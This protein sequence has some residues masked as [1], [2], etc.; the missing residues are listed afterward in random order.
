MVARDKQLHIW[1]GAVIG[2]SALV[3]HW[4]WA[5]ALVLIVALAKEAKDHYGAFWILDY[6][7]SAPPWIWRKGTVELWDAWA[8]LAGGALVIGFLN[9]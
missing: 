3:L 1:A 9:L 6:W 7:P 8:T 5:L 2:L 4:L